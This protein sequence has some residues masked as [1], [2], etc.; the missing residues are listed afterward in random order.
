MK[1]KFISILALSTLVIAGCNKRLD[2]QQHGVLDFNTYY[3]TDEEAETAINAVYLQLR[4]NE[5]NVYMGKNSPSDDAW[6]GGAGRNDN[7]N[8]EQLTE[9]SFDTNQ[10]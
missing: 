4:N 10:S 1:T 6:A 3:S 7:A 9:F 5:N 8:I 2:I